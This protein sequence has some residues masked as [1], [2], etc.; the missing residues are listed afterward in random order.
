MF[1]LLLVLL[2]PLFSFLVLA[3]MFSSSSYETPAVTPPAR[4][5]FFGWQHFH[6]SYADLARLLV[7][8]FKLPQI[9]CKLPYHVRRQGEVGLQVSSILGFVLRGGLAGQEDH[10]WGKQHAFY[11]GREV[12]RY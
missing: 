11:F 12:N 9:M 8:Q 1:T 5:P 7:I 2:L 4:K 6:S 10:R 3:I